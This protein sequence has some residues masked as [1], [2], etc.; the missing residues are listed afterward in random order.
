MTSQERELI[1][2]LSL[3]Q[4]S[5]HEF[6]R[7]FRS[8]SVAGRDLSLVLLEEAYRQ[9][10]PDDVEYALLVGFTLG[11]SRE[12]LDVLCRLCEASWHR[13]HEDVVS[14]LGQ[15]KDVRA[16][17]SLYRAALQHHPYLVFDESRALAVK[18]I[19]ALGQIPDTAAD[20]K[21]RVLAQ[22]GEQ[23]LRDE[24]LS[25]IQRRRTGTQS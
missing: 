10:N 8:G 15:L 12:H 3:K 21:L 17:D 13:K 23:V 14:A 25:Q 22:S 19:W 7:R 18:A 9:K 1:L 6:L 20:E 24:A 16:V 11:F 5:Q 2:D 4:V